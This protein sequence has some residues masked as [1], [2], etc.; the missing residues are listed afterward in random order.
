[1]AAPAASRSAIWLCEALALHDRLVLLGRGGV[2]GAHDA[3]L[4]L[5]RR[6]PPRQ[7]VEVDR[8]RGGRWPGSD[9]LGGLIPGRAS[10]GPVSLAPLARRTVRSR[11]AGRRQ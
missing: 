5:L 7:V 8:R 3:Q 6:Q 10:G 9:L 2:D 11:T 4:A 1:M